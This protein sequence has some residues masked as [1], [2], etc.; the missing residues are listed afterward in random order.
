MRGSTGGT[1]AWEKALESDLSALLINARILHTLFP[2]SIPLPFLHASTT[3]NGVGSY[4][5]RHAASSDA[6]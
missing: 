5:Y 2:T 3:Q 6:T 4:S 1:G